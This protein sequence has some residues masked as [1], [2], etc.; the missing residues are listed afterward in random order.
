MR[1]R[2]IW[3]SPTENFLAVPGSISRRPQ[4]RTASRTAVTLSGRLGRLRGESARQ[5]LADGGVDPGPDAAHRGPAGQVGEETE[6]D[7]PF[8]HGRADSPGLEVVALVLV[9]GPHRR[10]V[11][12]ADVV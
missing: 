1:T 6:N 5:S 4:S 3:S 9:D 7:E 2:A 12:A 8:G 10:G 11:T